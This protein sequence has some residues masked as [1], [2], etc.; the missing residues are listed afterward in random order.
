MSSSS[1]STRASAAA[2]HM[3]TAVGNGNGQTSTP[4]SAGVDPEE[5][6]HGASSLGRRSAEGEAEGGY[7][8]SARGRS[9][10]QGSLPS[11]G[12]RDGEVGKGA[13]RGG[14]QQGEAGVVIHYYPLH[15][16][17]VIMTSAALADLA[18]AR[19]QTVALGYYMRGN[20]TV[21]ELKGAVSAEER[22]SKVALRALMFA[23]EVARRISEV[24]FAS[25]R[26]EEWAGVSKGWL[27]L[28]IDE[29]I[30]VVTWV[31]AHE[32][33]RR[34]GSRKEETLSKAGFLKKLERVLFNPKSW[35]G[36]VDAERDFR[37][38][39]YEAVESVPVAWRDAEA[40]GVLLRNLRSHPARDN[41]G[42]PPHMRNEGAY[43]VALHEDVSMAVK[44]AEEEDL[45]RV[46]VQAVKAFNTDL[47]DCEAKLRQCGVLWLSL[48]QQ[49]PLMAQQDVLPHNQ[50]AP[51]DALISFGRGVLGVG[52]RSAGRNRFGDFH[53]SPV[54]DDVY[55]AE[56]RARLLAGVRVV[57]TSSPHIMQAI[58]ARAT[59][60]GGGITSNRIL[61]CDIHDPGT[62]GDPD[63][64]Q[65][66]IKT[67]QV[68]LEQDYG[69]VFDRT[70]QS[71]TM[72][73][74]GDIADAAELMQVCA[75]LR[76]NQQII[77]QQRL[78]TR[79]KFDNGHMLA[80]RAMNEAAHECRNLANL[81]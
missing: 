34:T 50:T 31:W 29:M 58:Q 22:A 42:A 18:T 20:D 61:E 17:K 14:A 72:P 15:A 53:R 32:E 41:A 9:T 56:S 21:L 4:G 28:P 1:R 76:W 75:D 8:R 47:R 43:M 19:E 70:T 49:E 10:T 73:T 46:V 24:I 2:A 48:D 81:R 62:Y 23:P 78:T 5:G 25:H 11:D 12:D 40:A 63:Y 59:L 54:N 26:K 3:T 51:H 66:M 38:R 79:Y 74:R 55:S 37:S 71:F 77:M 64:T 65:V 27:G 52:P 67:A 68:M 69:V 16:P 80:W 13:D 39:V 45:V 7:A 44:E 6:S 57:G 33:R 60:T 35:Q 36:L 30:A